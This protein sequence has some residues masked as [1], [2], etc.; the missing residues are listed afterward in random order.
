MFQVLDCHVVNYT[1]PEDWDQQFSYH[2]YKRIGG[3][4]L[5][6]LQGTV[7]PRYNAHASND[8]PTITH[9]FLGS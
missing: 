7:E 3:R 2:T 6:K 1:S 5:R 4:V 8:I 9:R